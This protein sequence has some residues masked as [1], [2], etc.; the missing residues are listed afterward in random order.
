MVWVAILQLLAIKDDQGDTCNGVLDS[1][2]S[3]PRLSCQERRARLTAF[4]DT[5]EILFSCKPFAAHPP[6]MVVLEFH[7]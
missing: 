3:E 1:S 4:G 5:M 6:T 7:S 2:N